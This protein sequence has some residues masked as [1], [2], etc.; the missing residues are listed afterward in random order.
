MLSIINNQFS[1]EIP[2]TIGN[3][4]NL[5]S[6]NAGYNQLTGEIPESI[7]NMIS[8]ERLWLNFNYLSGTV[9][10]T[11]CN[12]N[13]LNW[14]A[15]GFEGNESYLNNNQLCPLYPVCVIDCMGEQ[16][17]QECPEIQIGDLNDDGLLDVL[18]IV[19]MVNIILNS[20]DYNPLADLNEDGINNILDIVSLVNLVLNP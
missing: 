6:F 4:V 11:I 13:M 15:Y 16:D 20:E 3:L 1:G 12:L 5:I 9:P 18:D 19:T 8:L 7:G 10:M 14:S 17:I 2:E